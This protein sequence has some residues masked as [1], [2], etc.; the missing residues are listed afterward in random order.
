MRCDILRDYSKPLPFDGPAKK[1]RGKARD[2]EV[3]R[4]IALMIRDNL[5]LRDRLRIGYHEHTNS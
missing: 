1:L 2:D 3:L 4:I 5:S